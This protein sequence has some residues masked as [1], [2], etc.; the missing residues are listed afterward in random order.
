[1]IETIKTLCRLPG[2]SGWED[3]VR[4]WIAAEA[5]PYADQMITDAQGSLLLLIIQPAERAPLLEYQ[6]Y[7]CQHH[8]GAQEQH[9]GDIK[10]H[11]YYANERNGG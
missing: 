1:M 9:R 7:D 4:D 5:A 11:G 6:Q 2:P 10:H 3:A 8:Q